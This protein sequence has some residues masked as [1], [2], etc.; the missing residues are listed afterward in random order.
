M[1]A[2]QLQIIIRLLEHNFAKQLAE[3]ISKYSP[4]RRKQSFG[5][6]TLIPISF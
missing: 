3:K 2:N 6:G 5:G 1:F 4:V